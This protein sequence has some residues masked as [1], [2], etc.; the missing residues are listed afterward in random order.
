MAQASKNTEAMMKLAGEAA[1]P[2]SNRVALAA[3][4]IKLAA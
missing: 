4:K 1:Q 3:E 2:L